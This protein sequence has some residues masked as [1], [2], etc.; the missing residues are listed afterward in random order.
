MAEHHPKVAIAAKILVQKVVKRN[1]SVVSFDISKIVN[2]AYKAIL[3][4]GEGTVEDARRIGWNVYM[5]LER[6]V[7]DKPSYAPTVEH[8]QDIVERELMLANLPGAAKAY[9]LY[10][11]KRAALREQGLTV[12]ER[13]KKLSE[14]S[15][16]YFKNSLAEF[17]FYRSY[18]RWLDKEQRRETWIETVDRYLDFMRENLGQKVKAAEYK[19]LREAILK[20]EVMPSMRLMWSAGP[21]ARATNVCAYNCSFV[22]PRELRDFGEIMYLLM[23]GTGVGFSAES[24]N[25]H[26]LPQIKKQT[27]RHLGT[28]VIAD[29]KEGWADALVYGLQAWFNGED[30]DF[31][32]SQLRPAGARLKTMG[33]R[34]SG[35]A[36]LKA[37][38][39]FSRAKILNRQG[40][41]LSTLDVHD[42]VCKIGEI[43]VCGGVRRSAL[44]SLSDLDDPE[45]RDAKK[46]EFYV[47]EPQ[48]SM[49]NNSVAY[50][51]M[52]DV[53]TFLNEWLSLVKS[54]SGERGIFNRG[55]LK[56][57][58]PK[59]RLES[60]KPYLD[61]CGTNPCL[62]GDTLVYVAD[63]RGNVPI[64]KLARENKDVPVFCYDANGKVAVRYMRHPRLTGQKKAV[65]KLA[66]DDGSIIKVTGN[67]K[68]RLKT[69]EYQ[70]VKNLRPGTSLDLLTKFEASIKDIFT[71]A[72]SRSQ[73]YWW[74]NHGRA[75]NLAEHRLIAG[76]AYNRSVPRGFVVHHKDFNAQNNAPENLQVLSKTEHDALHGN[77]LRGANNPMRRA[78]TEWSSEK[79]LE[80][81][82]N[83]SRAVAGENNGRYSGISDEDLQRHALALTTQLGQRFSNNEWQSYA[84]SNGLPQYFAKWRQ[85]H[86]GNVTGLA[87]WAALDLGFENIDCDPR[88][89][90]SYRKYTRRGYDC[91]IVNGQVQINKLCEVCARKFSTTISGRE[92]GMCSISCGLKRKHQD[93]QF[94]QQFIERLKAAHFERKGVVRQKQAQIYSD[95]KFKLGRA[96]LKSEWRLACKG[97]GV[98]REISRE[99]SPFAA[100]ETLKEFALM[101]N[102]KVR[103]VEFYGYEDVYNGTVDEFHNFFIGGFESRTRAG[104]RKYCYLNNLQCGEIVLRSK[105]FCNLSEIVARADDTEADLLRK[106]R[107]ATILGTYQ[108]TLTNFAY[109][110]KE[111]QENCQE[112]RLLGVSITGQWDCPTSRRAGL[113]RKLK[114]EV[115]RVNQLFAKRFDIN[116]STCTTCVKPSGTVSQLVDAASGMH[117]RHAKYYIRRVRISATD[118]LY[119]MLRDQGVPYF[120]EVGQTMDT[121]TTLVL[122]FPVKAPD[123]AIFKD[124]VS[125][126]E[127]LEHW[128]LV[129][130]NYTE[131]NPSVTVS[132]G[133]NE[134]L[135]TANWV[136]GHWDIIGGLSFLPRADHVY[137]LAPYEEIDEARYLKILARFE[138]LD[139]SKIMTYEQYDDTQGAKELACVSGVCEA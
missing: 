28:H 46:G 106:A 129:K 110:S 32:Y 64:K 76:F 75:N 54:G 21:G 61:N 103:S 55:G 104:K 91:E 48:R 127:Q 114:A 99:S 71:E 45:M 81:S 34:S 37:L 67:H 23:C 65:Y 19:E 87:K 133:E 119:K 120:P 33:G 100:Y 41:R 115:N 89:L 134:W 98:S 56:N 60:F 47:R 94:R 124:D 10:R 30:L 85:Q 18:S 35:P 78:Q 57:Q 40:R 95:L 51:E 72:N 108:S 74:L 49:A 113:L 66:L 137:K 107:L 50:N 126:L 5:A 11:S 38:M 8:I 130:Q 1:G 73:D 111:W 68:F 138:H 80:Y 27:G 44:I 101:Y 96:P 112:E 52:P 59:R 83:M 9:I 132:V 79:W 24:Q 70:E 16:Q 36:P 86:L 3:A 105:Q 128:R 39:E 84:K 131:H 118:S 121:A 58:L 88:V 53:R 122:E 20:Q 42:L 13:V 6:T 12:P 136:Y 43:V 139:Y 63:G 2:A 77:H 82:N 125:A 22:A 62:T 102:H 69:G 7:K 4:A 14:E 116:P 109:L 97:A 15:Q 135:E 90:R 26:A 92:Y 29:S 31:D 123:G 17:I 25:V 117:P 93:P